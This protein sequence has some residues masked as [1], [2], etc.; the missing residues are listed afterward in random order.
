LPRRRRRRR[1]P[2]AWRE[3]ERPTERE[4]LPEPETAGGGPRVS[5]RAGGR[6]FRIGREAG[7]P[8][9]ITAARE[10]GLVRAQL[11]IVE[12]HSTQPGELCQGP[13]QIEAQNAYLGRTLGA[14]GRDGPT[15]QQ[16]PLLCS[17]LKG[18]KKKEKKN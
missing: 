8:P 7:A 18:R 10:L 15:R 6:R 5:R 4:R 17:A 16:L 12:A 14:G 1:R 3:A 2:P 11:G 9:A 13:I